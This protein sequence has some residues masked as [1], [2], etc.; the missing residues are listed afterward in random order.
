MAVPI[1][2]LCNNAAVGGKDAWT[3]SRK[4]QNLTKQV[5][6]QHLLLLISPLFD[7]SRSI[8]VPDVMGFCAAS[9]LSKALL[10]TIR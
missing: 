2:P 1:A 3:L 4:R 6:Q 10:E 9:P 8:F 7:G 5:F